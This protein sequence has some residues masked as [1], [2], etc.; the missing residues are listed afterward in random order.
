MTNKNMLT[1]IVPF[2]ISSLLFSSSID[3][4]T[5]NSKNPLNSE[6]SIVID[7]KF[8]KKDVINE[9]DKKSTKIESPKIIAP[10]SDNYDNN[11]KKDYEAV[12]LLLKSKSNARKQSNQGSNSNNQGGLPGIGGNNQGLPGVGSNQE[13]N[14][15]AVIES[16]GSEDLPTPIKSVVIGDSI[17]V[18]AL[19]SDPN[20]KPQNKS[21]SSAA[22]DP[23]I[24][25][26]MAENGISTSAPTAGT[27]ES[28]DSKATK[29]IIR[30]GQKF[31][32]WTVE[33]LSSTFVI[34]ENVKLK[35]HIKK[36]Y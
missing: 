36:Y 14:Q 29:L 25:P 20:N 28:S 16:D 34:Y 21:L 19:Y 8:P 3:K 2:V 13:F 17:I 33:K 10:K 31:N 32:G 5:D 11:N 7:K 6:K 23:L 35:K 9:G 18:Y 1:I 22:K 15:Q 24:G 27:A 26:I 4:N 30:L 12:K